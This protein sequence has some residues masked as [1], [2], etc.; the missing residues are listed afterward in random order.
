MFPLSAS[1]TAILFI[2]SYYPCKAGFLPSYRYHSFPLQTLC[3]EA[4][5]R[6]LKHRNGEIMACRSAGGSNWLH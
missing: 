4:T 5:I 6:A 2:S 3:E 1:F